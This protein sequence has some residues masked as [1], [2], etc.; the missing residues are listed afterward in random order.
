[1]A[2]MAQLNCGSCGYLCKTYSEAIASGTEKNLKLCSPGGNETAKV[3]RNL[4]KESPTQI[5]ASA[6]A[7]QARMNVAPRAGDDAC[8]GTSSRLP[9]STTQASC[10]HAMSRE[11]RVADVSDASI[12][13]SSPLS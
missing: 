1:M 5:A 10:E 4:M 13:A 8:Q 11:V 12:I 9:N 2:A 7:A 3:L 6:N